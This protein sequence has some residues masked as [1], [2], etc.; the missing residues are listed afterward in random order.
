[1]G[2]DRRGAPRG[3]RTPRSREPSR[4]EWLAAGGSLLAGAALG[5]VGA[6][7]WPRGARGAPLGGSVPGGQGGPPPARATELPLRPPGPLLELP[8][9]RYGSRSAATDTVLMFRGDPT[10]TFYGTGPLPEQPRLHW[11]FQTESHQR[12]LRGETVTWA[13]TGWTGQAVKLGDYVLVGSVDCVLYALHARTGELVWR[14]RARGMFKSSPCLYENRLYVGNVDDFVRCI[15]L[16]SG[17]ELWRHDTG[18]D[19]DS[20][21]CVVDGRVYV[22]GEAGYA[23]CLDAR[24][25]QPLWRTFVGGT[26]PGTLPGSNGSE[27]SPA[28][29]GGELYTGT[30]DG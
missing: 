30:F 17:Q 14:Y 6:G 21:P 5:S 26:G 13:G 19:C 25:G 16:T 1:M 24:T 18:N 4:R 7:S 22:A 3:P 8:P 29:D 27:T 28:V 11:T 15:D 2:V 9:W 10:H 23:W 20:S 12:Q